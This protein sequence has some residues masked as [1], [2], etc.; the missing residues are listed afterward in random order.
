MTRT[1][2]LAAS[3]SYRQKVKNVARFPTTVNANLRKV[4]VSTINELSAANLLA[5]MT[6]RAHCD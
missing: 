3:T 1:E 2:T 4:H 5:H 6:V